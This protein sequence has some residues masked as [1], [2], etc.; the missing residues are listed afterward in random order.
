[1][2]QF[3]SCS[4]RVLATVLSVVML[5][6]MLPAI[7][8]PAAADTGVGTDPGTE[9]TATHIGSNLLSNSGFESTSWGSPANW[10]TISSSTS[11]S[12][13]S[14]TV[15][16]GSYAGQIKRATSLSSPNRLGI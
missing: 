2:V 1:M 8:L 13:Q 5:I 15:L 4:K 10:S 14:N 9:I 16:S 3:K 12:R 11:S 7:L 6:G